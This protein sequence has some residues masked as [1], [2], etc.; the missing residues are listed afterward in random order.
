MTAHGTNLGPFIGPPTG[1]KMEITVF[2]E[3]RFAAGQLVEHWGSPDR[4]AMIEQL[5]LLPRPQPQGQMV[6]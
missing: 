6:K 1:R 4:F 5:G 2:D 3:C